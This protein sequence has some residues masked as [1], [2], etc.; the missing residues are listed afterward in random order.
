KPSLL[1]GARDHTRF[2][3]NLASVILPT[4]CRLPGLERY[5]P[6]KGEQVAERLLQLS[7]AQG[8]GIEELMLDEVFP[9]LSRVDSD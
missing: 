3:E 6:I 4:L 9:Q 7:I 5:R 2:G 1:L 8:A